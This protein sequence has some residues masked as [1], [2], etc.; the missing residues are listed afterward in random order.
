[1]GQGAGGGA[2]LWGS[3]VTGAGRGRG[4]HIWGRSGEP[5]ASLLWSCPCVLLQ[6]PATAAAL[7]IPRWRRLVIAGD[8]TSS[9]RALAPGAVRE[10]G[11]EW[12]WVA[13]L[14]CPPR[15]AGL[16]IP[17]CLPRGSHPTVWGPLL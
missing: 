12:G 3:G 8:Q 16:G 1:M 14:P 2:V 4:S 17:L 7:P 11:A 9:V 6:V 13:L 15:G 5:P 10:P